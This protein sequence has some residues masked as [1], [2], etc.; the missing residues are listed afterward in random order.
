MLYE[1][2]GT[3]PSKADEGVWVAPNACVIGSVHLHKDSNIWF[4]ATLRGDNEPITVGEGSNVQDGSICHTDPGC[5]LIIGAGVTVG[6][7]VMLHGCRIGDNSLV[8][9]G[10][11][12][13]NRAVIKQETLVGAGSLITEGKTFPPGVL[14]M[15]APARVV[16][17]LNEGERQIIRAS[18][19][20]Y[21]ENARRYARSLKPLP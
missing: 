14:I 11:T 7:M 9:M 8:G 19:S 12:I 10:S 6:H 15:G 18:A 20:H 13:L 16:R 17:P 21:C 2:D 3:A 1:L 5:P 4:G